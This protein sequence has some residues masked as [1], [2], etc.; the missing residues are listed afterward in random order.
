ME[1]PS[2]ELW[3]ITKNMILTCRNLNEGGLIQHW[4]ANEMDKVNCLVGTLSAH[5]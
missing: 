5:V 2:Q 1:H 4:K 3:A